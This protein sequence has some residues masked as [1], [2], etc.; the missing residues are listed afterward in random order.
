MT[1]NCWVSARPLCLL[2]AMKRKRRRRNRPR[3]VSELPP[4]VVRA[5]QSTDQLPNW[6]SEGRTSGREMKRLYLRPAEISETMPGLVTTQHSG[7]GT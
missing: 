2:A 1:Q 5:G 4:I 7:T 6:A 3:L